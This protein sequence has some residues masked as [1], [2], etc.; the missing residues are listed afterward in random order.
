MGPGEALVFVHPAGM[1]VYAVAPPPPRR[2]PRPPARFAVTGTAP[3]SAGAVTPAQQPPPSSPSRHDR[4]LASRQ[5]CASEA[6]TPP[7][8][9]HAAL[10]ASCRGDPARGP[11]RSAVRQR[12]R[13]GSRGA[14]CLERK[15]VVGGVRAPP[16]LRPVNSDGP[17]PRRVGFTITRSSSTRPCSRRL[18]VGPSFRRPQVLAG[19]CLSSEIARDVAGHQRRLF[20]SAAARVLEKTAF[21]RVFIS[22]AISAE[23]ARAASVGQ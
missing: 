17:A 16:A 21:G 20:Q 3:W 11:R 6:R 4:P 23:S 8:L 12:S 9:R 19:L 7:A 2:T 22:S 5:G 13:V 18:T 15:V 1:D 14:R 10:T